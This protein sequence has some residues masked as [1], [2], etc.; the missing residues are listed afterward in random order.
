MRTG[1]PKLPPVAPETTVF[2]SLADNRS[3][4]R[5]S[6]WNPEHLPRGAYFSRESRFRREQ[7]HNRLIEVRRRFSKPRVSWRSKFGAFGAWNGRS[8]IQVASGEDIEPHQDDERTDSVVSGAGRNRPDGTAAS[9]LL[10][11]VAFQQRR[12]EEPT[13][14]TSR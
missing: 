7:F 10:C 3:C 4:H 6:S 12:I 8:V 9:R 5:N 14:S 1:G 2:G 13:E 11:L